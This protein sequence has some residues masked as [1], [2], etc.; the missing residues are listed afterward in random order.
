MNSQNYNYELENI[1]TKIS[2]FQEINNLGKG[3]FSKVIK[4]KS[5]KNNLDYA[6]KIIKKNDE[7]LEYK[8][9][10]R[11]RVLMKNLNHNNIVH[12]YGSFEDNN[13]YYFVMEY[14]PGECLEKMINN[15]KN[16]KNNYLISEK[17]Y[18]PV[19]ES[20]V[21]NIF[22]QILNGLIYL[23]NKNI[24]HRDI[25]PDNILMDKKGIIKI[26][27]FGLSALLRPYPKNYLNSPNNI[28]DNLYS[29]NTQVGTR[30]F[31]CPEIENNQEYDFKCDIYSLGLT[32]FYLMALDLPYNSYYNNN[33]HKTERIYNNVNI[34]PRYSESLR[35]LVYKMISFNP[36]SRP[37]AQEA[38]NELMNIEKKEVNSKIS[39]LICVIQCLYNI[40]EINFK[41]IKELMIKNLNNNKN[42]MENSIPLNL[43]GI[44]E[45]VEKSLNKNINTPT[46]NY[47]FK[48]FR[49]LL[50]SKS[51][52]IDE[53][54]EIEPMIFIIEI[55]NNFSIE[56]NKII[57]WN[58]N[59]FSNKNIVSNLSPNIF[60]EVNQKIIPNFLNNYHD[61]FVD[62][63]YFI[64][65]DLIQCKICNNS[66]FSHNICFS[67]TIQTINGETISN[68]IKNYFCDSNISSH[69][70]KCNFTV[71][72][73]KVIE[74]LNSPLYLIIKLNNNNQI[75]L[76]DNIDLSPFIKTNVGPRRYSLYA[77]ISH[78]KLLQEIHYIAT[79]KNNSG[80]F[81]FCSNDT[82]QDCGNEAIMSGIPNILIYKG[83]S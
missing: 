36:D 63:F 76:D 40:S 49:I 82:V 43:A 8:N 21:I 79:I 46:F 1:G 9:I 47:Y 24:L 23:H 3:H 6:I 2:D 72:G 53:L 39:S 56:F 60:S 75:K 35:N 81:L 15:Y 44:M 30:S 78:E 10:I 59:I 73:K 71:N 65:F 4:M 18:N 19:K 34:S 26:T 27:D 57:N 62:L 33:T 50:S 52:L 64:S 68:L 83:Q 42:E 12:L 28:D 11:E 5:K 66:Y 48:K 67:I 55:F 77:A 7:Y 32:I 29:N 31:G 70:P 38:Y 51:K 14:I 37:T 54:S 80:K 25:K 13:C 69:C 74:L 17:R 45:I 58:N 16:N 20:M 41:L 61:P 22:K